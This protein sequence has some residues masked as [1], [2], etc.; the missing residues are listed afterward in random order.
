MMR[1]ILPAVGLVLAL[2][3]SAGMISAQGDCV[4]D[5]VN[6]LAC[7]VRGGDFE[8]TH[9]DGSGTGRL[10]GVIPSGFFPYAAATFEQAPQLG[11]RL[12]SPEDGSVGEL[13]FSGKSPIAG[14]SSVQ[15]F[16]TLVVYADNGVRLTAVDFQRP[17][18]P[19]AASTF[20]L[21]GSAS[22][23]APVA[24]GGS[25]SSGGGSTTPTTT[26]VS[27]VPYSGQYT[28]VVVT[29]GTVEN[30]LTRT[31]YTVRMRE[32]PTT[33]AP[34]LD[35]VP[36]DTSM[37]A[38]FITADGQWLRT[39]YV[40]E[41]GVGRL[42]WIYSR[43]LFQSEA[44]DGLARTAPIGEGTVTV[45]TGGASSDTSTGMDDEAM[46]SPTVNLT[47]VQPGT[48][49][50]CLVRTTYTV[51]G[52][53]APTTTAPIVENVPYNTSMPADFRTV[54]NEWVRSYYVAQ[55]GVGVHVWIKARYLSLSDAC[56]NIN[57]IAAM[58]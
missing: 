46:G 18:E 9:I 54:D 35:N 13:Y 8:I 44:C 27:A 20:E 15:M 55:G 28:P 2:V 37:P 12:V 29:P 22:A 57:A 45:T 32:A 49:E 1:R 38:D 21:P 56:A 53:T 41:G 42:G 39:F 6:V 17:T 51:R 24:G 33:A 36:F 3:L 52:R 14:S 48:V 4:G 23:P 26:T 7:F 19:N 40:G 11:V 43:Y 58:P 34:I 16:W 25:P 50:S 47:V 30:C 5:T 10:I 31:T